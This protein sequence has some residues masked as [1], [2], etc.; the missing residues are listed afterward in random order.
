MAAAAASAAAP[1]DGPTPVSALTLIERFTDPHKKL[2]RCIKNGQV[3]KV[4]LNEA[5][6]ALEAVIQ[7]SPVP[8][9]EALEIRARLC[10]LAADARWR[11]RDNKFRASAKKEI[12]MIYAQYYGF[13]VSL[14][15]GVEERMAFPSDVGAFYDPKTWRTCTGEIDRKLRNAAL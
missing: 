15:P 11:E 3:T 7:I 2:C 4:G 13:D 9:R 14:H 6:E 1:A 10:S 12:K 5:V 8:S